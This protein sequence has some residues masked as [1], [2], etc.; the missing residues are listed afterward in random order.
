MSIDS[1]RELCLVSY[2]NDKDSFI[3]YVYSRM[4]TVKLIL[5]ITLCLC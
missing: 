2:A 3:L 1:W 4:C 5:V